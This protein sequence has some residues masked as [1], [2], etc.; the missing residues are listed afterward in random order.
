MC[1]HGDW[2]PLQHA[3]AEQ[4]AANHAILKCPIYK[5]PNGAHGLKILDDDYKVWLA[6]TCPEN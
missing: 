6:T 3:D 1:T 4:Q 2:L 5:A